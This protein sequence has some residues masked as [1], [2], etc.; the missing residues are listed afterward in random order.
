[1]KMRWSECL[2]FQAR[3]SPHN[4]L[5]DSV[6]VKANDKIIHYVD[7]TE[8]QDLMKITCPKDC[9]F[10]EIEKERLQSLK[11]NLQATVELAEE[12][13]QSKLTENEKV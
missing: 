10:R 11:V 6:F 12:N 5:F 4:N 7:S 9:I 3:K 2:L 8:E 1:M 13:D